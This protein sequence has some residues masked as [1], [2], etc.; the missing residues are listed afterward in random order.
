MEPFNQ[1]MKRDMLKKLFEK[2]D[3]NTFIEL[4][5][6]QFDC[7]LCGAKNAAYSAT[8]GATVKDNKPGIETRLVRI[9]CHSCHEESIYLVSAHINQV[10]EPFQFYQSLIYPKQTSTNVDVPNPDMPENALEIYKEAAQVIDISPRS[11]NALARLAIQMIVDNLS[12]N[13][14]SSKNLNTLIGNLVSDGLPVKF[15][16]YLDSVRVI[17]NDSVHPSNLDFTDLDT[18]R[19]M[20]LGLL[21]SI[22]YFVQFAYTNP[23]ELDDLYSVLTPEQLDGIDKRDSNSKQK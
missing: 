9:C 3:A 11:A 10:G 7:H 23:K 5:D 16:K 17:G 2:H 20:A 8:G 12:K 14:K 13:T 15:Q 22:N 4:G 21:K 1:A 18:S 6:G 19:E